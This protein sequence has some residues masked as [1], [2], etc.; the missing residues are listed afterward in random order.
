MCQPIYSFHLARWLERCGCEQASFCQDDRWRLAVLLQAVQVGWNSYH[1]LSLSLSLFLSL[2]LSLSLCVCCVVPA[3]ATRI[4]PI[5]GE[6]SNSVVE[7]SHVVLWVIGS[8]SHDGPIVLFI[9]PA[10]APRLVEWRP[11]YVFFC[12]FTYNRTLTVYRK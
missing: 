3:S 1:S 11:W 12:L 2:S 7:R 8:V 5:R 6:R 9:A 4:W 10:N